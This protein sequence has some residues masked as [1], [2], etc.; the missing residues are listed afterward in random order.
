MLAP[1]QAGASGSDRRGPPIPGFCKTGARANIAFF[2]NLGVQSGR[3]NVT[4]RAG[5]AK[6]RRLLVIRPFYPIAR[7]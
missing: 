5:T 1:G 6:R 7:E 3:R 4:F 2:Q